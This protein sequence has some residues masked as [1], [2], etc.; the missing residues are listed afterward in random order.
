MA[1]KR[2]PPGDTIPHTQ[3]LLLGHI[4]GFWRLRTV[5]ETVYHHQKKSATIINRYKK[6][7]LAVIVAEL[8]NL[9][10]NAD[11]EQSEQMVS[12]PI[13]IFRGKVVT[14][15]LNETSE[16]RADCELSGQLMF[17]KFVINRDE[18]NYSQYSYEFKRER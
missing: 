2:P 14:C 18:N 16:V 15:P 11:S 9:I 12:V 1:K 3:P 10:W 6:P 4:A 7:V 8:M 17:W 5:T 13:H